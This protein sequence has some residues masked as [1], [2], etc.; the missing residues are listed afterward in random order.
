MENARLAEESRYVLLS[1]ER[2]RIA[3]EMHDGLSQSLFS[4]SLGL[5][6][7]K[8]QVLRDPVAV[9]GRLAGLQDQLNQGMAELRRVIYD[10]RPMN[11]QAL[12]LR[13]SVD[14]WVNEATAGRGITGKL[15]IVG[16]E[17]TLSPSAEAC[18]YRVAK[19][20][21]SNSVRHSGAHRLGVQIEYADCAIVLTITDDGTG[22]LAE[23]A[24]RKALPGT[25]MGLRSMR[26]RMA[27]AGGTLSVTSAP[28]EGTVVRAELPMEAAR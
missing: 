9:S 2:E 15:E 11:L 22:F 26:E 4:V 24:D 18:L 21:V 28:G 1:S 17:R 14:M 20:A 10:L 19:E 8:K 7:C 25:G 13:G 23:E 3:R 16:V 27:A 12:G 5:E 6:L